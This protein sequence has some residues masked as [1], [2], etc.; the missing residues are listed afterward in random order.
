M[1]AAA[2]TSCTSTPLWG[3]GLPMILGKQFVLLGR[4]TLLVTF[5]DTSNYH[6]ETLAF[7]VVDFFGPYHIIL[8]WPCYVKF[9]AIPSYANLKLKIP[10]PAR[11]IIVEAK[12]QRALDCEQDNIELAA[13][14]IATTELREL[15]LRIPTAPPSLTIPTTSSIFK[16]DEDAMAVQI[17]VG[18]HAKTVQIAASLDP[19]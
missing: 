9:M 15:S 5:E 10:G 8:G 2:S 12:T 13:A 1:E 16:T 11:V 4:V 19:K 7:E 3:W 6:T 17:D 18:D 14:T